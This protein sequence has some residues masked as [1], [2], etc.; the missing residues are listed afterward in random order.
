[1][2]SSGLHVRGSILDSGDAARPAVGL[3]QPQR[4]PRALLPAQSGQN[5]K[6][7]THLNLDVEWRCMS[8]HHVNIV[9]KC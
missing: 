2:T 1:M 4:V 3:I 9:M 6:L 5:V 7:T 8:K